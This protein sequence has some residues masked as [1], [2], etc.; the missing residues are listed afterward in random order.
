MQDAIC[1]MMYT[2]DE[3]YILLEE[4]VKKYNQPGFI[5]YDPVQ[6]PKQFSKKE[7]I[8]ILTTSREFF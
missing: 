6:I 5:E 8:E 2:H 4:K 1:D 7:N 3:L